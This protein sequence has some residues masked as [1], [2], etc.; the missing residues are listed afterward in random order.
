MKIFKSEK[1]EKAIKKA[2][3]Q[4]TGPMTFENFTYRVQSKLGWKDMPFRYY[5]LL[6]QSY[7]SGLKNKMDPI[8]M[9]SVA[10]DQVSS[11]ESQYN[12]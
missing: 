2:Q 7:N 9:V 4:Q 10:V 5:D 8:A 3:I 1:Y 12:K 6:K 11:E